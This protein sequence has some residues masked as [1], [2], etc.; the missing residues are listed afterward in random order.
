MLVTSDTNLLS[1]LLV[2]L[3][4]VRCLNIINKELLTYGIK[5]VRIICDVE[6]RAMSSIL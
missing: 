5:R 6:L 2:W 4:L 3:S 1:R